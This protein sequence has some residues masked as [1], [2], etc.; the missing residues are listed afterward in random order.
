MIGGRDHE[1]L[2][3][4]VEA[5][6]PVAERLV[7]IREPGGWRARAAKVSLRIAKVHLKAPG[8]GRDSLPLIAASARE[9]LRR[10]A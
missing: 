1:D 8:K 2:R 5:G 4:H 7:G 9:D 10:R 3:S 6:T